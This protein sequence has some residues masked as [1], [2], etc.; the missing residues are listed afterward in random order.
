MIEHLTGPVED[1]GVALQFGQNVIGMDQ[2]RRDAQAQFFDGATAV[3]VV[4]IAEDDHIR[5]GVV[6]ETSGDPIGHS[7]CL[8]SAAQHV[9]RL[10]TRFALPMVA[11]DGDGVRLSPRAADGHLDHKRRAIEDGIAVGCAESVYVDHFI[12]DG[13]TGL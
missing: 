4:Q 10:V 7:L 12:V 11:D 6:F 8:Q 3:E 13:G 1:V 5:L 2:R 9:D